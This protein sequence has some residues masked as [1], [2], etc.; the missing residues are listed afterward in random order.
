MVV[1]HSPVEADGA[2]AERLLP[3]VRVA[4]RLLVAEPPRQ[5]GQRALVAIG[6]VQATET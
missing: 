4:P 6:P 1:V 3:V 5:P 2:L